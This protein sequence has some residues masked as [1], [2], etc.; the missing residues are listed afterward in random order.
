MNRLYDNLSP[1]DLDAIG[2]RL[3]GGATGR[4]ADT[5]ALL[6][7][8]RRLRLE[9]AIERQLVAELFALAKELASV[10]ANHATDEDGADPTAPVPYQLTARGVSALHGGRS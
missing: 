1:A 9:L 8:V 3:A 2:A 7:E 4:R 10:P 5:L 6:G